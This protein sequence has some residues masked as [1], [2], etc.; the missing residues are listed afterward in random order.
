MYGFIDETSKK[1][2][3]SS[4]NQLTGDALKKA[5]TFYYESTGPGRKSDEEKLGEEQDTLLNDMAA[6]IMGLKRD[7]KDREQIWEAALDEYEGEVSNT[8]PDQKAGDVIHELIYKS[9]ENPEGLL[10]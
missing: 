6:F 1:I 9:E 5:T 3:D 7:G 2:Y 8:F 4:G 10:G